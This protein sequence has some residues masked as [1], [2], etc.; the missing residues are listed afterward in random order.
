MSE[1]FIIICKECGDIISQCRCPGPDKKKIEGL[2]ENCQEKIEESHLA[3][4]EIKPCPCCGGDGRLDESDAET[5]MEIGG[6]GA[7]YKVDGKGK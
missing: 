1:H 4:T 5:L 7:R 6:S 2:C 3:A